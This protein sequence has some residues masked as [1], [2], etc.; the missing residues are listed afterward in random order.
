MKKKLLLFLLPVILFTVTLQAQTKLWNFS[1]GSWPTSSG[2]GS[3]EQVVD[4]LGMFP[5]ATN[6]NFGAVNQSNITFTDSLVR[7]IRFQ[8]NG[9]GGATPPDY[10]PVQRYLYFNVDGACTVKVWF[11]TGSN[12]TTRTLFVTAGTTLIGSETTNDSGTGGSNGD[13]AII[14]CSPSASGKYYIYGDAACNIY[15]IEVTGANVTTPTLGLND[16][17]FPISTNLQALGNR[18]FVSNVKSSSEIKIYSITGALVKEF[19]TNSDMDFSF[20][21]GLYIATI[22]TSEGQKSVKLLTH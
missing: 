15:Q 21:S 2:I 9:G 7:S 8:M 22:K 19:K 4:Q 18:I 12:G 17:A 10:Q 13:S 14:T 3:S 5:I 11:K 1:D 6:T 20:K 16:K